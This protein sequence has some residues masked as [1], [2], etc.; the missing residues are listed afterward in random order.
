MRIEVHSKTTC[1]HCYAT[2]QYLALNGVVYEEIIH[3]DDEER[4]AFYDGIGLADDQRSV[5]QIIVV[6]PDG[7]R[8]RIGGHVDL[9]NSDVV[10]RFHAGDFDIEF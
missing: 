5:P 10:A 3:D 9:I 8:E 1:M 2:K 6:N 7:S 4:Y